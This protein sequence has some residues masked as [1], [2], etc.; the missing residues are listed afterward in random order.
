MLTVQQ[1]FRR[2][3]GFIPNIPN[4]IVHHLSPLAPIKLPYTIRVDQEFHRNPQPTI[5]D[6]RVILDDPLKEKATA[7]LQ[8]PSYPS[9]LHQI[10]ELDDNIALEMQALSESK[11]RHTFFTAMS[12]DPV[13]FINRWMSS[14]QRDLEIILGEATRGGGEDGIS[15]EWRRG[16]P[17]GVW[18]SVSAQET[19]KVMLGKNG[20][21]NYGK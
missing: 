20:L 12:K 15:D 3:H 19:I 10:G 6:V 11:S 18:G 13:N 8:E 21:V 7:I 14:Q 4:E 9:M 17:E 2:E 5:Y 1:I 16:G